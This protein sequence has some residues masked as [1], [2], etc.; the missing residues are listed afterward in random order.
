VRLPKSLPGRLRRPLIHGWLGYGSRNLL[1]RRLRNSSFVLFSSGTDALLLRLPLLVGD[2]LH[3]GDRT[4]YFGEGR[5]DGRQPVRRL[6]TRPL[7]AVKTLAFEFGPACETW[8][9]IWISKVRR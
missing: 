5:F 1:R 4:P 6:G 3:S 2:R 7:R 8:Q 9:A